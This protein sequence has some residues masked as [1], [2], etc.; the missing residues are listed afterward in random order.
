MKWSWSHCEPLPSVCEMCV[1][2]ST[3]LLFFPGLNPSN[4][5]RLNNIL[6]FFFFCRC[7]FE[8][9]SRGNRNSKVI[10]EVY[11]HCVWGLLFNCC[12]TSW[13][14]AAFIVNRATVSCDSSFSRQS[15]LVAIEYSILYIYIWSK[16]IKSSNVQPYL[17]KTLPGFPL[18]VLIPFQ[19]KRLKLPPSRVGIQVLF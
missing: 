7:V 15:C 10:R 2:S 8:I 17:Y 14:A 12:T 6:G 3:E 1:Y 11:W 9:K 16:N 19:R 5:L 13:I 4:H 18:S